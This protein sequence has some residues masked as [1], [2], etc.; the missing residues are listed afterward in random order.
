MTPISRLIPSQID[1]FTRI[2]ICQIWHFTKSENTSTQSCRHYIQVYYVGN[3]NQ[4]P[5]TFN[6]KLISI[7]MI[8]VYTKITWAQNIFVILWHSRT[9]IF[10]LKKYMSPMF[11]FTPIAN[12]CHDEF[13]KRMRDF[14]SVLIYANCWTALDKKWKFNKWATHAI[15]IEYGFVGI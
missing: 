4:L 11:T 2:P 12:F 8:V 6:C 1:Y 7:F 3:G 15:W 10:L 5:N 9:L 13:S 14:I